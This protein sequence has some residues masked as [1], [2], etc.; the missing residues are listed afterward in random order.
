MLAAI[1]ASWDCCVV[2]PPW[3]LASASPLTGGSP[4]TPL[5]QITFLLCL[6]P[7]GCLPCCQ[8]QDPGDDLE[9]LQRLVSL[10]LMSVSLTS[11]PNIADI[12][13]PQGLCTY[14]LLLWNTPQVSM[15]FGASSGLCSGTA[16][17][18]CIPFQ[19]FPVWGHPSSSGSLSPSPLQ[20]ALTHLFNNCL[21]SPH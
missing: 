6:K 1:V 3:L 21:P 17:P 8:C 20:L 19:T 4:H 9:A 14:C 13:L 7:Q 2:A 10:F 16:L 11:S 15:W 12:F 18:Q 5:G